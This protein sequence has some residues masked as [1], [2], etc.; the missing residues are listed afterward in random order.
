MREITLCDGAWQVKGFWPWVPIKSVSMELGQELLGICEWLPATVPGGVHDDLYRA[1]LIPHPYQDLNSLQCEWVEN[2]WWMY[3]TTIE[4]IADPGHKIE[5]VFKGLDYEA[6]VYVDGVR[7]GEHKGMFTEAV[8]DLTP[9][10][11]PEPMELTVLLL[12]APDEMGQIGKTSETFT[13]KSRFNYKWDFSTRLVNIGIWD[14]VVL[15]V[16]QRCKLGDVR[17][18]TDV[19]DADR[20]AEGSHV[21]LICVEA[22]IAATGGRGDSRPAGAGGAE[23]SLVLRALCSSPDGQLLHE[24]TVRARCGERVRIDWR[25]PEAR[26]WYPNGYGEQPLYTVRLE[27]IAEDGELL[28]EQTYRSGIRKLAYL[29][30]DDSPADALPYTVQINNRRIYIR[31]V[32]LGPLDHL[33]GNVID[34]QYDRIVYMMK[35]ANMNLVRVWGGGLIERTRLYEQCDRH[36]ILIWQEFIQSSSGVDNLPS[37]QPEF[38][39]LLREAAVAALK[40][41]RNYVSLTVWSGGNELMSAP[42]KPSTFDDPNLAMLRELVQRHDPQR[43]CLPTSASGPVQYITEEKGMGHDVHGHWK[44]LDNPKH[45]TFYGDND[46]LFHSEFGVDG[47]SSVKSLR[48]FLSAPHLK[49]VSMQESIVWRH[50]GEWWDTLARDERLFGELSELGTFV[51]ASQW[52]QAEGLRYILESN[53]RRQFRNSGS[54]IWQMSEPWPNVSCTNLMDYYGETKMS[55]YWTKQAFAPIHVSLD[56]RTLQVERGQSVSHAIYL[57]SHDPDIPVEIRVEAVDASGR[58][59]AMARYDAC[60]ARD[61][62]VRI[63]AITWTMPADGHELMLVRIAYRW[64]GGSVEG[65]PYIFSAAPD[66]LLY[67][68]ALALETSLTASYLD[69]WQAIP[70]TASELLESRLLVRNLGPEAALH[71]YAEEITDQYLMEADELYVTLLPGES[72]TIVVRCAPKRAGGFLRPEPAGGELPMPQLVVRSFSGGEVQASPGEQAD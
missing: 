52:V 1:G 14:E 41:R 57:H 25:L 2:R 20:I 36:G 4:P 39:A 58:I 64:E 53:R 16:Q 21:G 19:E 51:A 17:L 5:L 26:L 6:I 27:L 66:M 23:E 34:S 45:Y 50:H 3:R 54:I 67:R 8:F 11:R 63:G 38:L 70:G 33:Y 47:V 15:R 29:A 18:V 60:S 49:P 68:S 28:D 43:L 46:N 42:N 12:H 61:R 30:N 10:L 65:Y 22:S 35:Q 24:E 7:L 59:C 69:D 9:R 32:N 31:G 62:S 37:Q 48:K 13:Q 56:Y 44:Y 71:V 72:R 40:G 55:Y